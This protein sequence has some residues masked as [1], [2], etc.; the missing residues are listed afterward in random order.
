MTGGKLAAD[1]FVFS[2]GKKDSAENKDPVE[3]EGGQEMSDEAL[4]ALWLR[5]IETK[6]ADFLKV[7][8]AMQ[9]QQEEQ[10]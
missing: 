4:Q 3:T 9:S 10:P 1:D 7:K 8:F 5:R 2:K 6:P